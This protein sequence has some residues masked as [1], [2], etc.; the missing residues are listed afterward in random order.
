MVTTA[1][2]TPLPQALVQADQALRAGDPAAAER[3]LTPLL[4]GGDP[5]LLHMLGLAKMHQQDYPGAAG[6]FARARAADPK[7][8]TLAFSHGTA[9]RWLERP[10][11]AA[12]AF[13]EAIRLKPGYAEAYFEAGTRPK[14]SFAPGSRPFPAI[15]AAFS[16]WPSCYCRPPNWRM[17]SGCCAQALPIRWRRRCTA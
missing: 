16:L 7:A 13:G 9:L 1:A 14:A 17:P 15:P 6:F 8:A 12:Q 11:E 4:P 10:A 3:V 2:N 5:R